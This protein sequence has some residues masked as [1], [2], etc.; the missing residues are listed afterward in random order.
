MLADT[1][2]YQE[3]ARAK[4]RATLDEMTR[5]AAEDG[6]DDTVDGFIETR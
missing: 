3:R 6:T 4:R 1:I 2:D 5:T